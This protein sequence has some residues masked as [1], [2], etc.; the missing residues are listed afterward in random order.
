M[1]I[2][3]F[4]NA[5]LYL[6]RNP[7]LI[8]AGLHTD[9]QLWDHYVQYGAFESTSSDVRAPNSWFDVNYY[10]ANY[11]DLGENGVTAATALDHYRNYGVNE[12][13][14]FNP[15][16]MLAPEN[17]DADG[18]AAA[19][20][21]LREAFDIKEDSEL[22]DQQKADLLAHFLA[23]GYKEDRPGVNEE[24]AD[25]VLADN[26]V[27]VDAYFADNENAKAV[28]GTIG[29]DSFTVN[30]NVAGKTIDGLGGDDTVH[31]HSDAATGT[32]EGDDALHL[33]NVENVMVHGEA[34]IH[35]EQL[36]DI[37]LAK[38]ATSLNVDFAADAVAGS[39]DELD[40]KVAANEAALTVNG[41][42]NL[43]ITAT[44]AVSALSV[45]ANEARGQTMSV[46][47]EGGSKDGFAFTFETAGSAALTEL[48]ID[49]SGL[50]GALDL[51]FGGD[52]EVL[53]VKK[54]VVKGSSTAA[55][56]DFTGLAA[57]VTGTAA[58][59]FAVTIEGGEGNDT[60]AAS[61]AIDHFTGGKGENTFTFSAGNSA[62]QVSN[63]KV[64]AM[65]TITDFG[66]KDTLEGVAGLNI[67]TATGTTPE[68]I[69]LEELATTLDSGSVFDFN[70]DTYVLV[71]GD[72]DLANV[73]L[74]KLAGVDL[75]KLQVGDNGE[76]AFA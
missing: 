59:G 38:G 31:L 55:E 4:F 19:N 37:E 71:N 5:E 43:D 75:E 72:A 7:D 76:L 47:L 53:N 11:P 20:K 36:L 29:D 21:D 74:V 18:Y 30:G 68:G 22:T 50:N 32:V 25:H 17:F 69:T 57:A 16:P 63:G 27:D 26:A 1:A 41:I 33:R 8:R 35:S 34:E 70:D 23:Y 6:S 46:E 2:N 62:V 15:N 66:A 58:N 28:Q 51:S 42:E 61:T 64:Q 12:G 48:T 45:T 13:R 39:D 9:E 14:S 73:E 60:F 49:G 44:G 3:P 24:F 56:Q 65:D 54:L 10:L 52:Q 40:V 67:V